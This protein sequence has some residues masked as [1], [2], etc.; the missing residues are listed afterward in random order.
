MNS[1]QTIFAQ[2]MDYLPLREFRQCVERYR[3]NYKVKDFSCLDQ[4]LCM[5]FAQITYPLP[6]NQNPAY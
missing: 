2:V 3:G 4:F 5:A 1:G 6:F